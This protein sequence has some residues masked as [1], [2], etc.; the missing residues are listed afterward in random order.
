MRLVVLQFRHADRV[1]DAGEPVRDER[2]HQDEENEHCGAV[3]DV[4]VKFASYATQ[5]QKANHLEGAE[6]TADALEETREM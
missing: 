5:T 3:L 6:E 1:P 2:E 4:V